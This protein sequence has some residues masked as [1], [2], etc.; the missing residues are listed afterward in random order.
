MHVMEIEEKIHQ[1][2]ELDNSELKKLEA[3]LDL[4]VGQAKM[5][6]ADIERIYREGQEK[7]KHGSFPASSFLSILLD[8]ALSIARTG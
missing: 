4:L 1:L 3:D 7:N 8:N 6:F 5:N 2:K